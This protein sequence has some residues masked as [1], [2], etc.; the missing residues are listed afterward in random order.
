MGCR[1]KVKSKTPWPDSPRCFEQAIRRCGKHGDIRFPPKNPSAYSPIAPVKACSVFH[2]CRCGRTAFISRSY[3]PVRS[4]RRSYEQGSAEYP[5]PHVRR[6][7]SLRHNTPGLPVRILRRHPSVSFNSA[8]E[9][10]TIFRKSIP[11]QYPDIPAKQP[12]CQGAASFFCDHCRQ[13]HRGSGRDTEETLHGCLREN[14][15]VSSVPSGHRISMYRWS[16]L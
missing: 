15:T 10:Y 5:L 6:P 2:G 1:A 3:Y 7:C 12:P 8:S 4:G 16:A 14:T 13:R 9:P 11:T